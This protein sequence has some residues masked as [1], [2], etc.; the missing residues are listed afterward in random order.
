MTIND[1]YLDEALLRR[2]KRAAQAER[3]EQERSS[4]QEEEEEEEENEAENMAVDTDIKGE[5]GMEEDD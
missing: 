2:M 3:E 5:S 4:D 1:L